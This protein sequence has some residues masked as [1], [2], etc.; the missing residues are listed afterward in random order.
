MEY[1]DNRT[2]KALSSRAR[3]IGLPPRRKTVGSSFGRSNDRIRAELQKEP[4]TLEEI[5]KRVSLSNSTVQ[6]FMKQFRAE[7]HI[8]AYRP[9]NGAG[10]RAAVWAWGVRK[11]AKRPEAM[12]KKEAGARYYRN[13]KLH[14]PDMMA[15]ILARHKIR[16][17]EKVG[18]LVRRDPLTAAFYGEAA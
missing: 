5:A 12:T 13:V 6:R 2:E 9:R 10:Y 7:M 14:R 3:E 1:F 8:R 16:Y 18:K 4:G 11:D 17:A 15:R